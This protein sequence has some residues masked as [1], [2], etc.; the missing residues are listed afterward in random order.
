MWKIIYHRFTYNDSGSSSGK[1][2][3]S[4]GWKIV[5]KF[6]WHTQRAVVHSQVEGDDTAPLADRSWRYFNKNLFARENIIYI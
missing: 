1:P 3:S 2:K 5:V 4:V 6:S